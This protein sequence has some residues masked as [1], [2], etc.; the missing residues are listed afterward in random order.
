MLLCLVPPILVRL[1]L[2]LLRLALLSELS[3]N[4]KLDSDSN[5]ETEAPRAIN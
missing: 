1:R 5:A 4:S 2:G 3:S